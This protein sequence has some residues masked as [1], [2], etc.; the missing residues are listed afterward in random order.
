[1]RWKWLAGPYR[2]R[3]MLIAAHATKQTHQTKLCIVLYH[4]YSLLYLVRIL[5]EKVVVYTD[6][7]RRRSFRVLFV[8]VINIRQDCKASLEMSGTKMPRA[9]FT[10]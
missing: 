8:V 6:G 9:Q 7:F 1:M 4:A 10:Y 3:L 2:P 5:F